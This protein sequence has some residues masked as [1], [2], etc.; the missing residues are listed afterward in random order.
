MPTTARIPLDHP[1]TLL[2]RLTRW[3]STRTY[4]DVL[5]P[6]LAMFHNRKVVLTTVIAESSAARWHDLDATLKALAVM[7]A[8]AAV[9]CSWCMDFGHWMSANDGVDPRKLEDVPRWRESE[10]F[11]PLE[12]AVMEYAEAM[13]RTPLEVTDDM[14]AA[15][16]GRLTDAALVELTASVALENQRAR[17]NAALGL[18]SQG[19]KARCELRPGASAGRLAPREAG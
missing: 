18:T 13:S 8:A 6:G 10:V 7:A 15:L 11:T 14:V 2:L 3:Y 17:F 12:R 5:E 19:F 16:R 9:E 4:G 1:D